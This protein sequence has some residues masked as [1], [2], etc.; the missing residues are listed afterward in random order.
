MSRHDE[1][2]GRCQEC[3][4]FAPL[5]AGE[6]TDCRTGGQPSRAAAHERWTDRQGGETDAE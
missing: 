2:R 3:G 1:H 4:T 6:C 5:R